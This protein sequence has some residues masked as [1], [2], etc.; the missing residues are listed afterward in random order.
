M[1]GD[2]RKALDIL[3]RAIDTAIARIEENPGTNEKLTLSDVSYFS[4][5]SIFNFCLD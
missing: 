1:S 4:E 2:I 5:F 3:R